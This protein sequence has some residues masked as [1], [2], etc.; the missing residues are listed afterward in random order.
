M[1]PIV[2]GRHHDAAHLAV[3]PVDD[4]RPQDSTYAREAGAAMGHQRVDQR[5]PGVSGCRVHDHAGRLDQDDQVLVLEQ[6][7]EVVAFRGGAA[8]RGAGTARV[9][10]SPGLTRCPGSS[11]TRSPRRRQPSRTSACR[12]ERDICGSRSARNRSNRWPSSA[13]SAVSSTG[14]MPASPRANMSDS[15]LRAVK[16]FVVVSGVLIIAGTA[17]LIALMVKRGTQ[18]TDRAPTAAEPSTVALPP[19]GEVIQASVAGREL[20]LLGRAAQGQ[21][22][23]VVE[24]ASGERRRLVWLAPGGP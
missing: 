21:F 9:K 14:P 2:L 3:E 8:A 24:L 1:R 23:L 18:A 17:T 15:L 12:R 10:P 4:A 13:A 5:A 20:V 22:V 16:L 11:I 19:G 7:L 6:H